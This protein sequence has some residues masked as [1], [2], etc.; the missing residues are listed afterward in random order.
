MKRNIFAFGLALLMSLNLFSP[1]S[2]RADEDCA[3]PVMV[4]V[5]NEN[6]DLNDANVNLLTHKLENIVARDGFGGHELA[7]L[8]LLATVS[9]DEK[10]VISGNRPV[11]AMNYELHLNL[12]NVKSG[13]QFG[14]TSIRLTGTGH[15]ENQVFQRSLS[16]I[17]RQNPEINGFLAAAKSKVFKYYEQHIPSLV[18]QANL[19]TM[20][21]EY[22][23]ALFMLA[24]IPPCCN[25]YD[26]VEEAIINIWT[27][28]INRE[29]SEQLAKA[30]AIWKSSKSP[31]AAREAAA[32]IAA[33]NRESACAEQADVLLKEIESKLDAD[34]AREL[35][36]EDE[37][38]EFSRE[39]VREEMNL[40]KERLDIERHSIDVI[41]DIALSLSPEVVGPLLKNL[42]KLLK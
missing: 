5:V 11:V 17:T 7:Y 38:R 3:L 30:T 37:Q 9:Q 20:R 2:A 23:E 41:R 15:N 24:S 12:C 25:N 1:L 13:E 6:G 36:L 39:Q 28:Y 8:C 40:R 21:G 42:P 16:K 32:V 34:Y 10:H 35:A 18:K 33:I 22:E 31:E 14:A 27:T 4:K 26:P 19:L 29:C